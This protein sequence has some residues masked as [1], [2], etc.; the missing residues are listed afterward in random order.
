MFLL[1]SGLVPRIEAILPAQICAHMLILKIEQDKTA[2]ASLA[3]EV[4][5]IRL[6]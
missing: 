2:C 4:K 5:D 1:F 6:S 3:T